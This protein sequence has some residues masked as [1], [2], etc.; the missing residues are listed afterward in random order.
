MLDKWWCI[1]YYIRA[2]AREPRAK[3]K[4]QRNLKKLEKSSR[5]MN[6]LVIRYS[7]ASARGAA[8]EKQLRKKFEKVEK[9]T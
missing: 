6:E 3:R 5:Q 8:N 9:S 4:V 2:L 7:G 1:C